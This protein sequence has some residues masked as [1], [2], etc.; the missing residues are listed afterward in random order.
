MLNEQDFIQRMID[1]A[2]A[3]DVA[4]GDITSDAI[5]PPNEPIMAEFR[6]KAAGVISGVAIAQQVFATIDPSIEWQ[7]FV[8]D[9]ESVRRGQLIARLNGNFRAILRGEYV[10]LNI[11]QRMSGIATETA[12]YVAEIRGTKA[13][14][15][16]TRK[17]APG[18]RICDK[19]AVR[20]GGGINHRMGL[21]DM[22]LIN[23]N[24]IKIAGSISQAVESVRRN[25]PLSTKIEVEVASLDTVEEAVSLMVDVIMLNNMDTHTMQE[26]LHIINGRC[27]T[28]ASGNMNRE[29]LPEVAEIG[30]DYISVGALTHSV[31]A[32][33]IT[34]NY[35]PINA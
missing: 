30:V 29:R 12:R 8:H 3:E 11:L 18:L 16:D 19:M 4:T 24:H 20:H 21:F 6:T 23:D 33:E 7:P 27:K 10:A 14:I 5:V 28:E 22:V 15:L 2:I 31:T 26:A 9:G 35:Y 32:L 1:L 34:M 17:T 13:K 25:M